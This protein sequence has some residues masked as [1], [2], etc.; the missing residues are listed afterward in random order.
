MWNWKW[1]WGTNS[2]VGP[3]TRRN[4][5][6]PKRNSKKPCNQTNRGGNTG[7]RSH[8]TGEGKMSKQKKTGSGKGE[9]HPDK[10]G[11]IRSS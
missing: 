9:I 10:Q 3:Q 11:I 8:V 1:W 7:P 2:G 5:E 4:D 6:T